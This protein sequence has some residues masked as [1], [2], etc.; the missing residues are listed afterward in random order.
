MDASG[1]SKEVLIVL[2]DVLIVLILVRN[3][4]S[5]VIKKC[6]VILV[7]SNTCSVDL[8]RLSAHSAFHS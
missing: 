5:L 7:A 8:A 1:N 3:S 6:K 4:H 2:S